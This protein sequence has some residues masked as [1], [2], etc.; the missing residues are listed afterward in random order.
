MRFVVDA[1]LPSALC[2][3]LEQRGHEA[4]YVP[5]VLT[6][7]TSDTIIARYAAAGRFVVITKDEDFSGL[8]ARHDFSLVWLRCGNLRNAELYQWLETRFSLVEHLLA[9]GE[10]LIILR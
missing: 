4:A 1:Q 10:R 5:Q 3:W 6:G 8:I 9:K 7:D 2:Q